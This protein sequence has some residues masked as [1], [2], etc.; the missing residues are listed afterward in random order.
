[1]KSPLR[2]ITRCASLLETFLRGE[3]GGHFAWPLEVTR[4]E[5]EEMGVNSWSYHIQT[6]LEKTREK[7]M[8]MKESDNFKA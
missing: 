4:L 6:G 1:M 2:I 3:G 5:R 8:E 7:R